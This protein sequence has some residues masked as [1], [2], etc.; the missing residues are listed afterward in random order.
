MSVPLGELV[1]YPEVVFPLQV[2]DLA[3]ADTFQYIRRIREQILESRDLRSVPLLVVGN[4]QDLLVV[5]VHA[6]SGS[7]T[8]RRER[9]PDRDRRR[10][11]V[12]LVKKHWKCTY[13]ECS[14]KY[15]WRIVAV[16]HELV[17]SVDTAGRTSARDTSSP[18]SPA[19]GRCD[20]L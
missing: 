16:F 7:G 20:I 4:K 8:G 18:T 3:K 14:A 1:Y 10:D 5:G 2:F 12:S 13:V 19:R 17:R 15:N 11:I 9:D 6:D